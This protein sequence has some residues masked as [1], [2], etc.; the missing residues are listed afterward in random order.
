MSGH[1]DPAETRPQA[2]RARLDALVHARLREPFAWGVHDCCLFAADAVHAQTGDDPA[3]KWR[4]TY[5]DAQGAARLVQKLGGLAAIAGLVGDR[6][7]P[8]TASVGD[9]GLVHA[10]GREL[11]AVCMGPNWLCPTAQ[12]LGALPLDAAQMAWR[13]GHD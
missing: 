10:D 8:L 11:L 7:P 13:V 4:G 6:I 1:H 5:S 12:G 3:A 9:V 2:W